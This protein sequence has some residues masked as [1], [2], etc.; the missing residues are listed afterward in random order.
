MAPNSEYLLRLDQPAMKTESSVAAPTAKKN[1]TPE[2]ISMAAM[3]RPI[4]TTASAK[5]TG[6]TKTIGARKWTTLSAARGTRS[7]LVIAFSPSATG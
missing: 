7:S 1:S 6:T 4:G 3:F 5:N 2:S